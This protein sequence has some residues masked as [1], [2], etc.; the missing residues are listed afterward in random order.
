[1]S[2]DFWSG[3]AVGAIFGASVK[4][5]FDYLRTLFE[6][7]TLLVV[8]VHRAFPNLEPPESY[9]VRLVNHTPDRELEIKD[10]W[11][12]G[13]PAIP[14]LNPQR[15]LPTRIRAG[16]MWETWIPIADIP[17]ATDEVYGRFRVR[18]STGEVYRSRRTPDRDI[19]PG[20]G[21]IAG[22]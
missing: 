17:V 3:T 21:A 7:K 9:F 12:E 19:A 10:V 20:I 8:S 11:Y 14:V 13:S 2:N 4:W 18:L 16:A 5:L 1:M 6:R 15:P 22:G